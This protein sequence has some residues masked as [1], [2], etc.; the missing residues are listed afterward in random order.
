MIIAEKQD[1][2]PIAEISKPSHAEI[3]AN[4]EEINARIKEFLVENEMKEKD[5]VFYASQFVTTV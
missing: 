4:I 2:R 1:I 3:E 5:S